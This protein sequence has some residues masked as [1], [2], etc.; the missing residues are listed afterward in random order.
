MTGHPE[1]LVQRQQDVLTRLGPA[2][3]GR[4][5][6]LG[7]G[8]AVALHLWHRRSVDLDWFTAD[9]LGD[10]LRLAAQL[11]GLGIH[12]VTSQTAAGTLYGTV[13]GVRVS[14][15]QYHYALLKPTVLWRPGRCRVA[16]LADLAA[17]KLSAV[18]QRGAK[19]DF[20][21]L[22]ALVRAGI[23]LRLALRSYERK[24]GVTEVGHV[25]YALSYFD[26]AD[27]E[28][29]PKMLWDIDWRTVKQSI[30]NDLLDLTG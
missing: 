30:R 5:F 22:F 21:D 6:Y 14:L 10:P 24:Y 8:T 25:L 2:L 27:R 4:G 12:F 18:A 11:R 29:M 20:V 26:D 3:N 16:S 7:G 9:R 19:K 13:S 28:R 17:M 1:V 15:I 23:S